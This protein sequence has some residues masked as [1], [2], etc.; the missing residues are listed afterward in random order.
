MNRGLCGSDDRQTGSQASRQTGSL[1]R[2]ELG[3]ASEDNAAALGPP[4][5]KK[6]NSVNGYTQYGRRSFHQLT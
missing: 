1:V 2:G 3:W 4:G 5:P 6:L